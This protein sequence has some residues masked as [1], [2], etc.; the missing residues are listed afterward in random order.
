M[1]R[2]PVEITPQMEELR[3]ELATLYDCR[4]DYSLRSYCEWD[5]FIVYPK[6]GRPYRLDKD[7]Q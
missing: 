5:G 6:L 2:D 3:E 4:V 1:R 7:G